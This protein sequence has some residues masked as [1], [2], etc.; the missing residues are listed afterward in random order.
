MV[1]KYYVP[2][3]DEFHIGFEYE[4][5]EEGDVW[6]EKNLKQISDLNKERIRVKYLDVDDI[7][8]LGFDLFGE[9]KEL[10]V[11]RTIVNEKYNPEI[12]EL[13]LRYEGDFPVISVFQSMEA[14]IV[15][16]TCLNKSELKWLLRRT[17]I[18]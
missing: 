2:H 17:R 5:K 12:V 10:K 15:D 4:F 16:I 7:V 8:S 14:V 3:I 6:V 1:N 18:I 13:T 11:F 9:T